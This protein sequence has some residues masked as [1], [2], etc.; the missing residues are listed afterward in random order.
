MAPHEIVLFLHLVR[1]AS[2]QG[3]MTYRRDRAKNRS[4]LE[5]LGWTVSAMLEHVTTISPEQAL[6]LPRKNRHPDFGWERTCEFGTRVHGK[7]IYVKM[8]VFG[9]EH[10]A[11]GCVLSFHFAEK[12]LV[13]PFA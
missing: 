10:Q 4:T 5:T 12:P 11:R 7:D 9:D 13:F 1:M 8:T 6:C 3:R 2:E